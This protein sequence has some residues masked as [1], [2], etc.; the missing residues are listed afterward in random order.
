MTATHYAY[1]VN[2]SHSAG[3]GRFTG[4]GLLG[5][6]RLEAS[7]S[8]NVKNDILT[9]KVSWLLSLLVRIRASLPSSGRLKSISLKKTS[10][11]AEFWII[12]TCTNRYS[13]RHLSHLRLLLGRKRAGI[14]WLQVPCRCR[15]SCQPCPVDV[16]GCWQ[17]TILS[18]KN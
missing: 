4:K 3:S 11:A 15:T 10:N 12:V 7:Y 9:T 13:L 5:A 18:C 17:V 14:K 1:H 8:S 6:G 16:G 2:A